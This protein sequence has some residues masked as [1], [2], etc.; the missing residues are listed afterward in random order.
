[1]SW[2]QNV[3]HINDFFDSK[4]EENSLKNFI[5][6]I[7]ILFFLF[8]YFCHLT[9]YYK[10]EW[11]VFLGFRIFL[12]IKKFF[13]SLFHF[14][15][16]VLYAAH[17]FRSS[18][19]TFSHHFG[20]VVCI[21]FLFSLKLQF[22][23]LCYERFSVAHLSQI[24]TRSAKFTMSMD[25]VLVL[26]LNKINIAVASVNYNFML[27]L[28][29]SRLFSQYSFKCVENY[30]FKKMRRRGQSEQWKKKESEW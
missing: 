7:H 13:F 5:F 11:E 29:F 9:I 26:S 23:S 18:N 19:H 16:L 10:I 30:T 15:L 20:Y 24:H 1:M 25:M 3:I 21:L 17:S 14:I 28:F 2:I 6:F 4:K 8:L 27:L 12:L 22:S